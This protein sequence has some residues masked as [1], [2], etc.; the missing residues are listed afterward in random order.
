MT[1]TDWRNYELMYKKPSLLYKFQDDEFGF[2]YLVHFF[3]LLTDDF[4][5]F[6]GVMKL[7]Y[8]YSLQRL[9]S[10][11]VKDKW[12]AVGFSMTFSTLFM[13]IDCP[14][15]FMIAQ[16][17]FINSF[18]AFL[19][20]KWILFLIGAL[21][22]TL[23]HVTMIIPL[24]FIGSYPLGKFILKT[25]RRLLFCIYIFFMY[26]ST[27]S[28]V[29]MFIFDRILNMLGLEEFLK[30]YSMFNVE[31][32]YVLGNLKNAM[33]F[34]LFVCSRDLI[35]S[36]PQKF[37]N[38]IYYWGILSFFLSPILNGIPTG[39]RM[40]IFV[41]YFAILG[42][43]YVLS[44]ASYKRSLYRC[45]LKYAV[46]LM[47]LIVLT[48]NVYTTWFYYPYSNSIPY[49]IKGHLPYHIRDKYNYVEYVRMTGRDIE[50]K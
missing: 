14:M 30:S 16:M 27:Q 12:K 38:Y 49:I 28:S 20:K 43:V 44:L 45:C 24:L 46:Y 32:V 19:R 7:L 5:I 15:R 11:F 50:L 10:F 2:V 29:Y 33:L 3:R 6:N 47:L 42:V 39:F 25:D 26:M 9:F 48:K 31:A 18:I 37:G 36:M 21:F 23:F 13:L 8:L 22:S 34:C 1:G 40:G 4:W 17:F 35:L 41:N